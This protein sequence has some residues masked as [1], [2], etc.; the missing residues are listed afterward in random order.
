MTQC[1]EV[2]GSLFL[3]ALRRSWH[4]AVSSPQSN[5]FSRL[6]K[7]LQASLHRAYAPVPDHPRNPGWLGTTN[8]L[9]IESQKW[10]RHARCAGCKKKVPLLHILAVPQWVPPMALLAVSTTRTHYYIRCVSTKIPRT[11]LQSCPQPGR[12]H[13]A[14]L[15][16]FLIACGRTLPFS[17]PVELEMLLLA[18]SSN[19]YRYPKMAAWCYSSASYNAYAIT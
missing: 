18:Y 17:I 7:S 14:Q 10:R 11:P 2:P 13:P 5:I 16:R 1:C 15:H 19:L 6:N 3:R 9:V 8:F 4:T 12:H